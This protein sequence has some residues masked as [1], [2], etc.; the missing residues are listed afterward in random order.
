MKCMECNLCHSVG[1]SLTVFG[2][3]T[4]YLWWH[5]VVIYDI[6]VISDSMA[7]ATADGGGRIFSCNI[8][9]SFDYCCL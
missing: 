7:A 1:H 4:Q 8:F 2:L 3:Y 9:A 6:L 5:L